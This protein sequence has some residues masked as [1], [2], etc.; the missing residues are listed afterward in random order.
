MDGVRLRPVT[1]DELDEFVAVTDR[2]FGFEPGLVHVELERRVAELDRSIGAFADGELVATAGA[3]SFE[4]TLP[5]P[6]RPGRDPQLPTVPV[7]AVTGVAVTSTH[8]RR[9]ILRAMMVRQL[10][11]VAERGEPAAVLIASEAPIYQRFGYGVASEHEAVRIDLTRAATVVAPPARALRMVPQRR[12]RAPAGPGPRA[13]PP[14]PSGD[15]RPLAAVVGVR[16]L[17]G[18][19]LEGPGRLLGRGGV[20]R[21]RRRAARL[22]PAPHPAAGAARGLDRGGR[23]ARGRRRR[24]RGRP[25]GP[26]DHPRPRRDAGGADPAGRRAA[27]VAPGRPPPPRGRPSAPTSSGCA[28][29]T[30]SRCCPPAATPRRAGSCSRSTTP[31]PGRWR[32]RRVGRSPSTSAA[33]TCSRST[34]TASARCV[35]APG[36]TPDLVCHRGRRRAATRSVAPVDGAGGGG[37]GREAS[38]GA[39]ARADALFV[40]PAPRSA[41]PASSR[42]PGA[43][44]APGAGDRPAVG[45]PP[46][47]RG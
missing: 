47:P 36:A 44:S 39:A 16:P 40:A 5:G 25:L 6:R 26:P 46:Q 34:P 43:R 15:G 7:A 8:R 13:G 24:D 28:R 37:P 22:R 31:S 32:R 35:R 9:G 17:R 3:Y 30:W 27:P 10:T 45:P 29:S 38:P 18:P 2:A 19:H 1:D 4:L 11:D 23:R 41:P 21:A 14:S 20:G 42:P 12:R 33:P